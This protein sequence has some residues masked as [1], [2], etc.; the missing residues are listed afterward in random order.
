M[1]ASGV[2]TG[3]FP[4]KID[5]ERDLRPLSTDKEDGP[6]AKAPRK[7]RRS[8]KKDGAKEPPE[9][10]AASGSTPPGARAGSKNASKKEPDARASGDD[11]ARDDLDDD[12]FEDDDG[13]PLSEDDPKDAAALR[14]RSASAR[15]AASRA[16]KGYRFAFYLIWVLAVPLAL[17]V[18]T[19][20]LFTPADGAGEVGGLRTLVSEQKI[21]FGILFFTAFAIAVWR[22]RY[23]L[24]LSALAGI[25]G[26]A[27]VPP[28]LRPRYEEAG[29]LIE[30]A[31][32]ILKA[33]KKD[34]QRELTS[35]ER[36][37]VHQALGDLDDAM[38]AEP[39]VA[40]TFERAHN[41]ADRV[42]GEHLGR[43][44]KG[45]IREYAESI[46]IAIGVALLLRALA[47]EAFKIPSGSMIPTLMVGDH[48]FVNKLSYG[49]TIPYTETRLFPD[50]PPMR[51]DVMVFKYPEKPE[52][53][54]IKRVIAVPGD[55]LEVVDGRPVINGWVVPHCPV[56]AFEHDGRTG[57]L[58]VEYL[59]DKAYFTLYDMPTA[60]K[61][62]DS[63]RDCEG[64]G[65]CYAGLCGTDYKSFHV[66]PNEVWVMGDN[67]NN[68]HDSRSWYNGRGG[69]VPFE[70]IKGRAM[71]V[72]ATFG[73][74]GNFTD[75]MLV[76]VM[77]KPHL[78]ASQQRLQP[79]LDKCL[80]TVP[81]HTTPR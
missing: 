40:K 12:R 52:Q 30:E 60:E 75:R 28:S 38:N 66:S 76:N 65:T 43:W 26:R 15:A 17:A 49:P 61:T 69:G 77:G 50:L 54:F 81:E 41:K 78:P 32:R 59:E 55:S 1:G 53:D 27:D 47:V 16:S 44:R 64:E 72:F 67:R 20:W 68:S 42:I 21:P 34:I 13:A 24:P 56:G 18:G 2:G 6:S 80:R 22:F 45:E 51:G 57:E 62:C 48:I 25:A 11:D 33:R 3:H 5:P 79:A 7:G 31:R 73:P 8:P 9:P 14:S 29:A 36:E 19:V 37:D 10:V 58:Y 70:N 4:G 74:G 71:F 35:S 46:A 63:S 39:F 23:D